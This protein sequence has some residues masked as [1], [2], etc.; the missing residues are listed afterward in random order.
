[1]MYNLKIEQLKHKQE[2]GEGYLFDAY[3]RIKYLKQMCTRFPH[4][5]QKYL[6]EIEQIKRMI[7]ENG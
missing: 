3:G 2:K 5:K 7:K 6:D 1:M 4:H